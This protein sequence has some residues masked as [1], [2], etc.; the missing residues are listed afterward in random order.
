MTKPVQ[1]V[2]LAIH[3]EAELSW[4]EL[5]DAILADAAIHHQRIVEIRE[6]A[7]KVQLALDDTGKFRVYF[8]PVVQ[9]QVAYEECADGAVRLIELDTPDANWDDAIPEVKQWLTPPRNFWK[10]RTQVVH[11]G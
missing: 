4:E 3:K 11:P 6:L 7:P 8:T 9:S 2:T 1:P 5:R 10:P